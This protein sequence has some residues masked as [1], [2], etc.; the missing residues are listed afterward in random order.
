MR[1]FTI[2][3][4]V[5]ACKT[6]IYEGAKCGH[7]IPEL[8]QNHDHHEISEKIIEQLHRAIQPFEQVISFNYDASVME[9]ICPNYDR[10]KVIS[11]DCPFDAFFFLN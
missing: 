8:I 10:T 11:K 2:G 9:L 3:I 4:G 5:G 7:G 1:L 6:L